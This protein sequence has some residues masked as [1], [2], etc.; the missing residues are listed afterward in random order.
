MPYTTKEI[1]HTL[2]CEGANSGRSAVFCRFT[3]CNLWS[4]HEV[5]RANAICQFCDTDFVETDGLD[6]GKFEKASELSEAIDKIWNNNVA[7]KLNKLVVCTGGEPLLQLDSRLIDALHK[8]GFEVAIETNGT[9]PSPPNIDWICMSPKTATSDLVIKSGNE[10]KFVYPQELISPEMFEEFEFDYFYLVP[11]DGGSK[12]KNTKL[13]IDYC[14]KNPKWKLTLQT[15]KL[16]GL[17]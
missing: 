11:M 17:P 10:L 8:K 14:L 4:G 2:Q 7:S 1:F 3:G 9:Q 13:A 6:G 16:I 15:H 12:D 5:D